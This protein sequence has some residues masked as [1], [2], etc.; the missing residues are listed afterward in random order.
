MLISL[1]L[2]IQ[3]IG[4]ALRRAWRD[5]EFRALT[6]LVLLTLAL[7]TLFYHAVE[8]W[9]WLDSLYF[10]VITLAT[11]GYGDFSPQ[12]GAGKLFTIIYVFLGIGLLVAF[13]TQLAAAL[14]EAQRELRARRTLRV[15]RIGRRRSRLT[16][17][18]E[19]DGNATDG[20]SA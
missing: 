20:D 3:H 6:T 14:L 19:R 1:L 2:T 15:R 16:R 12:T 9:G 4:V 7:G 5:T 11:I 18:R 8:G 10:C 17:D 13:F